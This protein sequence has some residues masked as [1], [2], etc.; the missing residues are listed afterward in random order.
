MTSFRT[1]Y[2]VEEVDEDDGDKTDTL[3]SL[4]PP[5]SKST[6]DPYS[7]DP[8]QLEQT[9]NSLVENPDVFVVHIDEEKTDEPHLS[10]TASQPLV[11]PQATSALAQVFA[12]HINE[13]LR[14]T[15]DRIWFALTDHGVD[16]RRIP[17]KEFECLKVI[18]AAGPEG[19]LQPD[20]M[21]ATGQD[22]RSVPKRTDTLQKRG[23]ITKEICVAQ[24]IKTS[25]LRFKKY[26]V[27]TSD[28]HGAPSQLP[29]V[30]A[31]R[32]LIR[33]DQWW[34]QLI[35]SLKKHDNFMAFDDLRAEMV[36]S[37]THHIVEQEY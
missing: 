26:T 13:R 11:Q 14:T 32:R 3:F 25:I 36:S 30:D 31:E 34:Y 29:A 16:H 6:N 12:T 15:E 23:L 2:A 10:D 5:A 9:W 17:P 21:R 8:Q 24:G 37:S 28:E 4:K 19:I 33:Y 20:V 7:P 1:K 35:G 18:A 22:K 27:H